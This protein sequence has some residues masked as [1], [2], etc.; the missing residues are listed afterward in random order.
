M[1]TGAGTDAIDFSGKVG[2]NVADGGTGSNF[3]TS[4]SGNDTFF[5]DAR[6]APTDIWNTIRNF[7]QGVQRPSGASHSKDFNFNWVG[8]DGDPQ[9]ADLTL[10]AAP[11][12]GGP[13]VYVTFAGH[14]LADLGGLHMIQ[15]TAADYTYLLQT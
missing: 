10:H 3:L 13:E 2:R 4:G 12:A 5:D 1:P 7:H 6:G 15:D 11:K 14:S 8:S 9:A